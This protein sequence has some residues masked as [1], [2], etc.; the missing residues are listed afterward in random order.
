MTAKTL[1]LIPQSFNGF[2][3]QQGQ[4]VASDFTNYDWTLQNITTK[5]T[6]R[7]QNYPKFSGKDY[8]S[9]VKVVNVNLNDLD[10]D[11]GNLVMAMD[12]GGDG[13]HELYAL[14]QFGQRWYCLCVCVGLNT[15]IIDGNTGSFG[16]IFEADDP[17]WTQYEETQS[18]WTA[19]ADGD[20]HDIVLDCDMDVDATFEIMPTTSPAGYYPYKNYITN[21]NPIAATQLDAVDITGA[22]GWN[23]AALVAAGKAQA[24]GDDVFVYFDGAFIPYWIGGGG[25]NSTTAR[26]FIRQ[27]WKPGQFMPL[28]TGIANT[29]TPTYIEWA[30]TADVK[31][32][33]SKLPVKGIIR[34]NNEEFSYRALSVALCQA[35]VVQRSIRGTSAG[36]HAINDICWWVEH[37]IKVIYGNSSVSAKAYAQVYKPVFVLASSTI[38]SRVYS[39]VFADTNNVRGGAWKRLVLNDGIGK[40]NRVYS[41]NQASFTEVNPAVVMGMEI[42]SYSSQGRMRP[43]TADLA[44]QFYHPAGITHISSNGEKFRQFAL[45]VW[46]AKAELLASANGVQWT[47]VWNEATPASHNTWTAWSNP[48]VALPAGTKFLRFHLQGSINAPNSSTN[49]QRFEVDALTMTLDSTKVI[50]IA[51]NGEISNYQFSIE[52]ENSLTGDIIAVDYP[53]TP[54]RPLIIDTKDYEVTYRGINAIRGI[55]L[56]SIRTSWLRLVRGQTNRLVY[57]VSSPTGNVSILTKFHKRNQ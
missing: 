11:R 32:A 31:A 28:R 21:Y 15:Q 13:Q 30:I 34:V 10:A 38:A 16:Y 9:Q 14:D 25:W 47:Q 37:D 8:S 22:A 20:T 51:M 26:L 45:T 39:S 41:G 52:I 12:I 46:P 17:S 23:H 19:T 5:N 27:A 29:G 48:A 35:T 6:S 18:A 57:R 49:Y 33:L 44:W 50:Q 2:L 1:R 4:R 40:L 42:A 24:D 56:S 53:V 3:F 54:N 43:E 55:S 7:N 36:T